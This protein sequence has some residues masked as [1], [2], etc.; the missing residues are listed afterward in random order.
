MIAAAE[1]AI[2]E[3]ARSGVSVGKIEEDVHQAKIALREEDFSKAAAIAEKAEEKANKMKEQHKKIKRQFTVVEDMLDKLAQFDVN[4]STADNQVQLAKNFMRSAN[5]TKVLEFLNKAEN[6][7]REAS[8]KAGVP[9]KAEKKKGRRLF[10]A[11]FPSCPECNN[12][13]QGEPDECPYCGKDLWDSGEGE[14]GEGDVQL[15]SET[16]VVPGIATSDGGTEAEAAQAGKCPSCGEEVESDW[17]RC[18]FCN[19][20]LEAAPPSKPAPPPKEEAPP[21]KPVPI[22]VPIKETPSCASCGS[23]IEEGWKRC[24]VC[25]ASLTE[26]PPPK[27]APPP[28]EEAPPPKPAPPPKEEAPPPKPAPPPKEEAPPP[29]PTP[30]PPKTPPGDPK[31]KVTAE[32]ANVEKFIEELTGKGLNTAHAKNLIRLAQSFIKGGSFD[33]AER[34]VRKARQAGEDLKT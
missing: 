19:I 2:H 29:K 26:A 18:P 32:L 34:Y 31:A 9:L 16:Q 7:A 14:E 33:K 13:L 12:V 3:A 1:E 11:D 10:S 21:P 28:K 22:P 27:P 8:E 6:F 24:P 30:P 20:S 25:M 17:K 5:Y 4:T 15:I 23:E